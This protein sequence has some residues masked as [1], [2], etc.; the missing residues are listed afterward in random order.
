MFEITSEVICYFLLML[1][2][3][4]LSGA[5]YGFYQL[6]MTL[7]HNFK[8]AI[9]QIISQKFEIEFKKYNSMISNID[10]VTRNF[11]SNIQYNLDQLQHTHL[12]GLHKVQE[13]LKKIDYALD[14]ITYNFDD[15]KRESEVIK[16]Q[17]LE[18]QK[19]QR[20]SRNDS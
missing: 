2:I 19:L 9:Y 20:R 5:I 17:Q 18:I 6:T 15:L 12:I 8:Q 10:E 16:K 13:E 14:E 1:M 7:K 11:T 3:L 4:V